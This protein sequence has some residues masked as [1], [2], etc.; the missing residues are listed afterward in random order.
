MG[1]HPALGEQQRVHVV[2]EGEYRRTDLLAA[3]EVRRVGDLLADGPAYPR[4]GGDG[5]AGAA[6]REPAQARPDRGA[7]PGGERVGVRVTEVGDGDDAVLGEP[8]RGLRADPPQVRDGA[9]AHDLPPGVA[10]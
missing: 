2:E 6:A 7:E 4:L 10:V 3:G 9:L 5:A 8:R 1:R